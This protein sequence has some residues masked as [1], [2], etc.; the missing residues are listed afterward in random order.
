[1]RFIALIFGY[2]ILC[3]FTFSV[4]YEG[5]SDGDM[6]VDSDYD[7]VNGPYESQYSLEMQIEGSSGVLSGLIKNARSRTEL[8]VAEPGT[9]LFS[10]QSGVSEV[11]EN[12]TFSA[13]AGSEFALSSGEIATRHDFDREL[14]VSVGAS[15]IGTFRFDA[16]A[17]EFRYREAEDSGLQTELVDMTQN[18]I[19]P[20]VGASDNV[21]GLEHFQQFRFSDKGQGVFERSWSIELRK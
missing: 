3:G 21:P 15:G 12:G 19:C 1:M 5:S 7:S 6:R 11:A 8:S 16:D 18:S 4:D 14:D 2:F 20:F 10:E 9:A 17:E 13:A